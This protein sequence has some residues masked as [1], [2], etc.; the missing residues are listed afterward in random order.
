[1]SDKYG[2]KEVK[3]LMDGILE[4]NEDNFNEESNSSQNHEEEKEWDEY[5]YVPNKD[6]NRIKR[7]H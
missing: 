4:Q 5:Y 1:M 3:K 7:S 6:L 2:C